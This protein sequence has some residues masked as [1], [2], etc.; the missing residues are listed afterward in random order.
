MITVLPT[1]AIETAQALER[2]D[3]FD[4]LDNYINHNSS[5]VCMLYGI[6]RTGKTTMMYQAMA[7]LGLDNVGY[8]LCENE[9][10]W[11]GVTQ[12]LE[13]YYASG[14]RYVFIDEITRLEDFVPVASV[15]AD[16]FVGRGMKIVLSGTDSY[17]L[18]L[19]EMDSLYDRA[20][21]IHTTYISFGE[22]RRLLKNTDVDDFIHFGGVLS[23]EQDEKARPFFDRKTASRY[24]DTAISNNITNSFFRSNLPKIF[25]YHY[26]KLLKLHN[27]NLLVP[28]ITAITEIY[29]CEISE[30]TLK[31]FFSKNLSHYKNKDLHSTLD[32]LSKHNIFLRESIAD[33]NTEA[34]IAYSISTSRNI[35]PEINAETV[36]QIK[37][38]LISLGVLTSIRHVIH[39]VN[40]DGSPR[41][42]TEARNEDHIV[43]PGMKYAQAK[44]ICHVLNEDLLTDLPMADREIFIK[45]IDADVKGQILETTVLNDTKMLLN[46]KQYSVFKLQICRKDQSSHEI[47]MVVWDR[48][49]NEYYAF[50]V[51]HS[52]V[53]VGNQQKHLK[54]ELTHIVMEEHFG[55]GKAFLVLYR[56]KTSLPDDQ[57]DSGAAIS[58]MNAA[59]FL[60]SLYLNQG[61]NFEDILKKAYLLSHPAKTSQNDE[62]ASL[63]KEGASSELPVKKA[64]QKSQPFIR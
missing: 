63:R 44:G 61:D 52:V 56:G 57:G 12:Q 54:D 23:H 58:Y 64:K 24:I 18:V 8:I 49:K 17:A 50:E 47:D 6:R 53:M 1:A 26:D 13:D 7:E 42:N 62:S 27:E 33:E 32:L 5:K 22:Y 11:R 14:I 43:Q 36:E 51:K 30:D 21:T 4:F 60:Y 40:E 25:R 3:C 37:E 2:R 28:V 9:D 16:S 15:L 41:K 31:H 38:Y 20:V 19:S 39:H 45:Q 46:P 48:S 29:S 55:N 35:Y 34:L 59:D 10:S